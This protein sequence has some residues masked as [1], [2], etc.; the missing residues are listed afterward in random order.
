MTIEEF[1]K[2]FGW[3]EST[4]VSPFES[5]A[6][7]K[8]RREARMETFWRAFQNHTVVDFERGVQFFLETTADTF[9]PRPAHILQALRDSQPTYRK[10]EPQPEQTEEQRLGQAQLI[11][12]IDE[13]IAGGMCKMDDDFGAKGS[14]DA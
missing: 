9:F 8:E 14:V 7:T 12:E 1:A 10:L 5:K 6:L 2:S 4:C 3:M 11:A 13:W